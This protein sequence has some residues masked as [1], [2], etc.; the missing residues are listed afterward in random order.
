M[1][2]LDDVVGMVANKLSG[3]EQN[4]ELMH[5]ILG[6]LN[7]PQT[8]GISGLVQTFHDK[9]V[10]GV[11]SSWVSTGQ[12]LPISAEQIQQVLGSGQIQ[13]IAQK[14]GISP[15][16][17]SSALATLMPHIIDKLTPNGAVPEGSMLEQGLSLLKSQLLK[18]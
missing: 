11:I 6:L 18:K 2:L 1:G 13:Q 5:S 8:G 10:G 4:N 15:E 12:N 7:N 17:A 16:E 3:S 9:G 14:I